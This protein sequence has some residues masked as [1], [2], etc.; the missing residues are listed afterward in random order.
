[1]EKIELISPSRVNFREGVPYNHL[2]NRK[3][4]SY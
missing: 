3:Q 4:I 2:K 1:M